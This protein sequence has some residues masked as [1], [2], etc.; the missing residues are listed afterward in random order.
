MRDLHAVITQFGKLLA[1]RLSYILL[2]KQACHGAYPL[3]LHAAEA[4]RRRR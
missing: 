1:K 3:C 4:C 2:R